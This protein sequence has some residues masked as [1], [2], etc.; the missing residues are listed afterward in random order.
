MS[1]IGGLRRLLVVLEDGCSRK[2]HAEGA[3][4]ADLEK[5]Q[6]RGWSR[7]LIGDDVNTSSR[8]VNLYYNCIFL[9]AL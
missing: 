6:L 7:N 5:E 2:P 8:A 4:S 3:W 9:F 1:N